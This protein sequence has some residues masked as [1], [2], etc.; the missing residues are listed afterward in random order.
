MR[1]IPQALMWETFSH[2]RGWIVGFFLL[3]NLLPMLIFGALNPYEIEADDT[4]FLTMHIVFLP[5]IM[6]Q[7]GAGIVAAQGSMSRLYARP[8]STPSL[9]AWQMFPG[10]IMLAL[11]VAVAG[12][13]C[14]TL[15]NIHWPILGPSLF[16]VAAWAS[17]QVLVSVSQKTFSSFAL[18]VSPSVILFG[19]LHSR[20]GSWFRQPTHYWTDVTPSEIATL[21]GITAIAYVATVAAVNRDRC[22]EPMPSLGGWKWIVR[23]WE[24]FATKSP[25]SMRPF[26]SPAEAHFWYEWRLKGWAMPL[27]VIL[28]YVVV[29]S[30]GCVQIIFGEYVGNAIRDFHEANLAGGAMIPGVAGFVGLL[31]GI[32]STG[33][34]NRNQSPTLSTLFDQKNAEEMGHFL[35]T[36]PFTNADFAKNFLRMTGRS[37]LITWTIWATTFVCWLFF[38]DIM[39]RLPE[40]V[41]PGPIG[42]WYI[43][44]VVLGSW[45]TMANSA[46]IGLSGRGTRLTFSIVGGVIACAG[47][48]VLVKARCSEHAQ[49][50]V[51]HASIWILS[52]A[53]LL[54]TPLAFRKAV[55]RGLVKNKNLFILSITAVGIALSVL[56]LEWERLPILAYPAILAFAALFILPFA[57]IPLSIA[58]NRHR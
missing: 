9:V 2:G 1:S 38:A 23:T 5:L 34:A 55:Q 25:I 45:I 51:Y 10:G 54:V 40:A 21:A 36:R 11:E 22:G 14:S 4:A 27:I 28:G 12:W 7:F 52:A 20:Y 3:G 31:S 43:P 41:F 26:R 16:A 8:I 6:F 13:M 24:S 47:A 35:S 32:S 44:L 29:A 58:W 19:W 42:A 39:H 30:V 37:L 48:E 15:F 56:A 49:Q 53:I 50:I 57:T 17:L 33:S 46:I 18:A